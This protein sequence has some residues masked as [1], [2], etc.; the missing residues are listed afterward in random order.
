MKNMK[1]IYSRVAAATVRLSGKG[2]KEAIGQAVLVRNGYFMTAAHCVEYDLE[3]G[4]ALGDHVLYEIETAQGEKLKASPAIIEPCTDIAV[5]CEP[6][7]QT[8]FQEW[9]DYSDFCDRVKPIPLFRRRLS[10]FP[11]EFRVHIYSHKKVWIPGKAT[12][13]RDYASR[14]RIDADENIESGTSGGPIINDRGELVGIVSVSG[15][16]NGESQQGHSPAPRWALPAW[17]YHKICRAS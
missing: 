3:G 10:N 2:D 16:S 9:D 7:S 14:I 1:D 11:A 17:I 4:I 13:Y 12:I 5:L 8:F 15:G 6:D